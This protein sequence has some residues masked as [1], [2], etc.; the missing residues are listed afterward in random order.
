[1]SVGTLITV[2]SKDIIIKR[3]P[4]WPFPA[5]GLFPRQNADGTR[6]LFFPRPYYEFPLRGQLNDDHI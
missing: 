3:E 5:S 6:T 4:I 2:D 1:V